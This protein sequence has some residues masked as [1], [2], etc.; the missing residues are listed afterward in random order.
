MA[1]GKLRVAYRNHGTGRSFTAA[2]SGLTEPVELE[3]S[4]CIESDLFYL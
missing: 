3:G 2:Q 1:I 4:R